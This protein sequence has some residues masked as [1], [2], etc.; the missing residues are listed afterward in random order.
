MHKG[1][2]LDCKVR[3]V[4]MRHLN[5]LKW[6]FSKNRISL[7]LNHS[8]LAGTLLTVITDFFLALKIKGF[9][10]FIRS[11]NSTPR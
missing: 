10:I 5:I 8:C 9:E 4:M 1:K 11:C 7:D 6:F 2:D 3:Y